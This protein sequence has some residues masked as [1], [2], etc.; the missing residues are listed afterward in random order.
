MKSMLEKV[1]SM[2]YTAEK[3]SE[4]EQIAIEAIQ[5]EKEM[6]NNKLC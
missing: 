4:L 6:Q 1:N 3:M 2:L 5:S